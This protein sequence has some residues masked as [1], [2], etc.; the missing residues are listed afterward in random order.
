MLD[1]N[2]LL[3]QYLKNIDPDNDHLF[4]Y[5]KAYQLVVDKF[6]Y[7]PSDQQGQIQLLDWDLEYFSPGATLPN[8]IDQILIRRLND[9]V[10]EKDNPLILDCGA[11]I[12]FSS[13][14]Y[15]RQFPNA[16]IIAFE[17]DP[18]FAPVLRRNLERN[19]ARDVE[20]V[21]AAVW[22]ENGTS[23]WYS[24]GVDGS[25]LSQVTDATEKITTVRT[26][27]LGDYLAES[28]DLIKMDIEGAEYEVINRLGNKLSNVKTMSIECHLD[29]KTIILFSELLRNLQNAGFQ[30][31]I[32]SFGEWRDLIHRAPILP[33][34]HENY[35][36]VSAWRGSTPSTPRHAGWIPSA[37]AAPI[38]EYVNQIRYILHQASAREA[39]LVKAASA[40]EA[41]LLAFPKSYALS[42]QK[43]LNRIQLKKPYQQEIGLCWMVQ[44]VKY[45]PIADN[46][47]YPNRSTFLLYED[48][49]LLQPAHA[50]HEDIR[51][52][53]AGRY[54]H[55][56][57]V[58]Y[59]STSDGSDPNTN[60]REYRIIFIV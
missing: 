30:L 56:N 4:E 57:K 5:I 26:V 60:G 40:H 16:R 10:P 2:D 32:N 55:W 15:K 47:E 7:A 53:G 27:D 13:L 49:K 18:D 21:E 43:A 44:L 17:P 25:H 48:D 31:S 28:V 58:L 45:L 12:G 9:F 6:G 42:G 46:A 22:V 3:A 59:F 50:I 19:G 1:E 33:D 51:N 54:S 38:T 11:N 41:E 52:L 37:G 36:L 39:E 34:H 29:Q 24:E 14:S 20:I 8:F 35:V 23:Q